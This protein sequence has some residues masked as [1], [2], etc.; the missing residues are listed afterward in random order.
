M[1]GETGEAIDAAV[2]EA[3]TEVAPVVQITSGSRE[4]ARDSRAKSGPPTIAEW[5][6]FVAGI[7]IRMGTDYFVDWAFRGID[8]N[9]VTD[10]DAVRVRLTDD[11][12]DQIGRPI[13]ELLNKL[14]F[15]RKHGRAIIGGAGS[16]QSILILGRWYARVSRIAAK[17]QRQQTPG[18]HAQQRMHAVPSQERGEQEYVPDSAGPP[19]TGGAGLHTIIQPGTG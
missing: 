4:R 18:P 7:V 17:Y 12:C 16:A 5:Q 14:A 6:D 19:P 13:A 3:T 8:E 1:P 15:T 11:E 9:R 2:P 10:Q